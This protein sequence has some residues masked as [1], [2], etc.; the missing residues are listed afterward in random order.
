MTC[1]SGRESAMLQTTMRGTGV[2][3]SAPGPKVLI[4]V[5]PAQ[6]H[7]Q[8]PSVRQ[9]RRHRTIAAWIV[10]AGMGLGAALYPLPHDM[11]LLELYPP[12]DRSTES[13]HIGLHAGT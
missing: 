5:K 9:P 10:A 12:G 8:M 6:M 4:A 3:I 13:S 7:P 2:R 1:L 11:K